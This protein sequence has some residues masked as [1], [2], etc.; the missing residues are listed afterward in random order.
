MEWRDEAIVLS[1]R[2]H[3]ETSA[4]LEVLS[5]SHGRHLGLVH[6]GAS[7]KARSLL[8]PGNLIAAHW[9]ARL[10]EHL[11][12]FT[13]EP[14][15]LVTH[16]LLDDRVRLMGMQA[17]AAVLSA[18]LAERE[19]HEPVYHALKALIDAAEGM[20]GLDWAAAYVVFELGLL[21]E[22]GFGLDLKR[23]AVTGSTD[24]LSHVS[25]RSGRAVSRAAAAPYEG[26]LLALPSFL[27]GRQAG[28]P[29][30]QDVLDGLRLTAH[31]IEKYV[32]SPH[33]KP[34]PEA[35]HQFTDIV[36][37]EAERSPGES[38]SETP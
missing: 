19:P 24:D 35:R 29:S 26:K 33:F 16:Q 1:A 14:V 22:L 4:I 25:P 9:R 5:P 23:C 13:A 32:L 18:T 27:L 34:L 38:G 3:G 30:G 15:K 6:G 8:Q 12:S 10:S 21:A 31:F 36:R 20:D 7:R 2:L 37:T 11:G 17:A 28:H